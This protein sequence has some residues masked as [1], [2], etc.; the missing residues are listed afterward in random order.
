MYPNLFYLHNCQIIDKIFITPLLRQRSRGS[1]PTVIHPEI[2]I[3]SK[4]R[5]ALIHVPIFVEDIRIS[6]G[7]LC[8]LLTIMPVEIV[9][10]GNHESA[11][12][13]FAVVKRDNC[14]ITRIET[15]HHDVNV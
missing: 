7:I 8:A 4:I 9:N 11:G 2:E 10:I 14:E 3:F 12:T 1:D 13:Q 15:D 5:P 6:C